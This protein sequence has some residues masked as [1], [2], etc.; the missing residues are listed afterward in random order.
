MTVSELF[1]IGK[2][3]EPKKEEKIEKVEVKP[4]VKVQKEEI[5][6]EV[7]R[8]QR[9]IPERNNNYQNNR[10]NQHNFDNNRNN[11]YRNDNRFGFQNRNNFNRDGQTKGNFQ[12]RDNRFNNQN[13]NG[14]NNGGNFNREKRPLD[15]RGIDK[16]IKDIMSIDV[17]EKENQRDF[18][19]KAIDKAKFERKEEKAQRNTKNRKGSRFSEEEFDGGKLKGLKQ[20]DR[21]SNMFDDQEGG[22]LEYYDLTTQRGRKNKRK[23]VRQD[24]ER[25]Q[26]KNLPIN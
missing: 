4:E 16:N 9:Q 19:S 3:E 8:P 23:N 22:M 7:T 14:N 11:N 26:A 10:N 25:K 1:G 24:E 15:N 20:V 13:R 21:L 2:K 5:V 12:N 17:Q 18:S 6:E